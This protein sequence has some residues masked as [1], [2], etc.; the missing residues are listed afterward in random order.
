MEETLKI[1]RNLVAV[2][3]VLVVVLC[4]LMVN[5]FQEIRRNRDTL[6]AMRR[7]ANDAVAQFT[8]QLDERIKHLDDQIQGLD[9]KMQGSEDRFMRRLDAEL[10]KMLDRYLESKK[11]E[12]GEAARR[13][14]PPR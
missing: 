14:Q 5:Q 11:R 6:L 7:Q 8:P 12:L 13:G 1:L 10:P 4:G 3:V 2:L 9:A